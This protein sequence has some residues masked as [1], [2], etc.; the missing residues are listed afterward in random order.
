LDLAASQN[1][2]NGTPELSPTQGGRMIAVANRIYVN[3]EY[4]DAFE[5]RFRNRAGMVDQMP[6][7]ITN[8]VLRPV[9]QGDPYIVL[10]YWESRERFEE[11]TRSDAFIQG[12]ARSGT[13]PKEAFS[14]P[15]KL[16]LHEVILDSSR[17]DL[18]P[19]PHGKPFRH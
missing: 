18:A 9:N 6:G 12:H 15:N 13:L 14:G 2:Y 7:F 17:P 19:E 11:W 10:T 4:A 3:S 1:V 5:E 16:E 8:Q